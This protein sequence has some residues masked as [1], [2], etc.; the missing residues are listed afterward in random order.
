MKTVLIVIGYVAAL[1]AVVFFL[2]GL[3]LVSFKFF[4]PKM[5]DAKRTVFE[6]TQSFVHGKAQQLSKYRLEYNLAKSDEDRRALRVAI[7][8]AASDVDLDKL[9]YEIAS[10][11]KSIR[12]PA[13]NP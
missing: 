9:P 8:S 5:E 3:G 13:E 12:V 11:V 1:I 4:A 2:N 10:F 7:L 6:N